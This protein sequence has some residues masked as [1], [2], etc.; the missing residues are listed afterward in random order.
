[1]SENAT[2]EIPAAETSPAIETVAATPA[3][4]APAPAPATSLLAKA[5]AASP[6][7]A[8]V[9][10][11][12][13]VPAKFQV[14]KEDGSLDVEASAKKLADG[15]AHLEKRLGSGD[16]PP[17][18]PEE[19]TPA[20]PE[21]FTLEQ[22]KEDPMFSGFLKGAHAKGLT[23]DQ[24]SYV[25]GEYLNRAAPAAA[26]TAEQGEA[27]LRK[28]WTSEEAFNQGLQQAFKAGKAFSGDRYERIEQKF[29]SDP[30]FV[31]LMAQ[32]GRE[33]GEDPGVGQTFSAQETADMESLMKS[34]AYMNAKHPDH[35]KVMAQTKAAYAKRYGSK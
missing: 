23:N 3:A 5:A 9:D 2:I 19:Y 22:F 29:G 30:D 28:E 8:P 17:K 4:P 10:P 35:A 6:A 11:N 24:V 26:P 32:V 33:L 21:G 7:P 12:A 16:A 18:T 14:K 34:D 13:W 25:I 1:M 27:E 15:H 31:W 20:L